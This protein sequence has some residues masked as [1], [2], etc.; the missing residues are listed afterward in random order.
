MTGAK[1]SMDRRTILE[2]PFRPGAGHAPPFLA[3]RESEQAQFK[4]LLQQNFATSNV[5]ITGLR[6]M[7]KTVLLG[8]MQ[9]LAEKEGWI[10]VGNDLSESSSL[11]E[12]RLALRILTDVSQSLARVLA[13]SEGGPAFGGGE[14]PAHTN[15]PYA[16]EVL[17]TMYERSPGLPSD[18]LRATLVRLG[19]LVNR[20]KARGIVFAYDEAQCLSDHAER[21]EFPMS[22]LVETIA[23][24]QKRD[25]VSQ[26]LLVLSGLPQV[27]DALTQTRT[28]TER[29]FEVVTLDRLSRQDTLNAIMPPLMGLM[30]PLNASRALINKVVDFTSGYPYLIQFFG[31]ELVDQLIRYGGVLH[32]DAFPSPDVLDR[33]DASLF[34]ARWNKTS[35]KQRDFLRTIALRPAGGPGDF[36]AQDI[37]ALSAEAEKPSNAQASQMLQALCDRG[38]LYR[39]RHGRYAFTVPMS[40]AMILRR[41]QTERDMAAS[42]QAELPP[43]VAP[44]AVDLPKE[45]RRWSWAR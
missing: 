35:D 6:G 1:R 37:A 39:T 9:E 20:A 42:W 40:E 44:P 16:F 27:F 10:W 36:S 34:A 8:S 24:L 18:R 30:P 29:M 43:V 5:L 3:G 17:R 26:C 14:D 4:R 45:K 41:T 15:S 23:T 22:M 25:G 31:K 13:N 21:N 2:N 32:E 12:E 11:S 33:L 19:S 28:Y 38:L 7:G